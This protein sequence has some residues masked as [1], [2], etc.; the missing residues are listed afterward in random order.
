[1]KSIFRVK[2]WLA[3]IFLSLLFCVSLQAA[4][5]TGAFGAKLGQIAP[6]EF[7]A[8][9]IKIE[10]A[11]VVEYVV[12]EELQ[13]V[14]GGQSNPNDIL[15]ISIVPGTRQI[16]QIKA[17]S[18]SNS[19]AECLAR[20]DQIVKLTALK[21]GERP[22]NINGKWIIGDSNK[23]QKAY[24]L[25]DPYG[26]AFGLVSITRDERLAKKASQ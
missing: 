24:C 21:Y 5:V 11:G 18:H 12:P 16:F 3:A 10:E 20:L 6:V 26:V 23:Y 1:M 22:K 8:S 13:P 15:T 4:E 14:V 9:A 19:L 17:Y 25:D 2:L 7:V